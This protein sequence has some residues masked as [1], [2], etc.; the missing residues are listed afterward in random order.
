MPGGTRVI[1]K[2]DE[3]IEKYQDLGFGLG[4]L[5]KVKTKSDTNSDRSAWS[6]IRS[7]GIFP[8]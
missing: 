8:G 1:K 6:N 2:E 3:K 7:S 4:R 5:W